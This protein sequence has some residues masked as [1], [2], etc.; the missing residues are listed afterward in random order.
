MLALT[1]KSNR[2]SVLRESCV[3]TSTLNSRVVPAMD[4]DTHDLIL[5]LCTRIGMFIEDAS[6]VAL[7]FPGQADG[8][9]D[10][11][12]AVLTAAADRISALVAA[13]N[14]LAA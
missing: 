6:A 10:A 14:A 5:T 8:E 2:M 3:W 11:A 7:T 1:Q 9:R 13:I 12:I 4:D